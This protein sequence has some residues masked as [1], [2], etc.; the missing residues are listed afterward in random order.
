MLSLGK[1]CLILR[2]TQALFLHTTSNLGKQ[3]WVRIQ[4]LAKD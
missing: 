1:R 3:L 4:H 2:D